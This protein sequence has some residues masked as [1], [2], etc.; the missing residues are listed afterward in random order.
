M[1]FHTSA[2][3]D[4]PEYKNVL[5][6]GIMHPLVNRATFQMRMARFFFVGKNKRWG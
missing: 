2:E 4:I 3:M 6:T 5:S 1:E